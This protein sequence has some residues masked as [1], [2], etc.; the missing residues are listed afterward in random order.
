MG[1]FFGF[2]LGGVAGAF[3]AQNYDVPNVRAQLE[4]VFASV[5]KSLDDQK[6]KNTA[7]G[8]SSNPTADAA[9]AASAA[10]QLAAKTKDVV[11]DALKKK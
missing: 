6:A 7:P 1:F 9:A 8:A 4:G 5:N 10:I 2:L 11:E 3:A